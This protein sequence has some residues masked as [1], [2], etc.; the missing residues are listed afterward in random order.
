MNKNTWSSKNIS[1]EKVQNILTAF[2]T[3]ISLY[4]PQVIIINLIIIIINIES[5]STH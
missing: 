5:K 4:R 1:E 2:F 3:L